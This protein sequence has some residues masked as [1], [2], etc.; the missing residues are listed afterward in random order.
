M[1]GEDTH[2]EKDQ[3]DRDASQQ[4]RFVHGWFGRPP[5][6]LKENIHI[7]VAVYL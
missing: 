7:A 2:C 3:Q 5:E 4:N 6:A 1:A